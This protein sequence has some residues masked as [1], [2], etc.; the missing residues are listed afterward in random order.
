MHA[1]GIWEFVSP[2]SGGVVYV[3]NNRDVRSGTSISAVGCSSFLTSHHTETAISFGGN[4]AL[5]LRRAVMLVSMFGLDNVRLMLAPFWFTYAACGGD[6]AMW[7]RLAHDD[8]W[9]LHFI[10]GFSALHAVV[11][12]LRFEATRG[13]NNCTA[14]RR[15]N[16]QCVPM[17]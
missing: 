9:H 1:L 14:F 7:R 13:S 2:C 16:Q 4:V 5:A 11:Y 10:A 12:V 15:S 3:V 6:W 8:G 17:M